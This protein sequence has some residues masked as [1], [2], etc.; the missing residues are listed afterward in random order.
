MTK[1]S[2][3]LPRGYAIKGYRVDK[4]IGGGGFSIVYLATTIDTG[5]Q[6]VIKE[7]MPSAQAQR[8][9]GGRVEPISETHNGLYRQGIKRFFDEGTVLAKVNHPNIV[10]VSNFFRA[11]NTVYMV[12]TYEQ[13]K[14]LRWYI[15]RHDGRLSEKFIR[16]VF[17]PLLGG[18][19][20]LHRNELLHLDIKPANIFL[21]PGGHPLLLDFGA[22]QGPALDNQS[23]P[24]TLT[25]GFAPIEQHNKNELGPYSDTYAIG[26]SIFACMSGRAPPPATER[27]V[28]DKHR[29]TVKTFARHYSPQLLEAV[30]WCLQMDPQDRPQSIDSLLEFLNAEREEEGESLASILNMPI[31]LPW[32]KS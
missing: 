22:A 3:A 24:N 12:M 23:G 30:D 28:K 9:G 5:E 17:P 20:E 21:R 29:P 19:R 8:V 6:V 13:G 32:Q 18:I 2:Q 15:K 7:C 27:L 10:H 4:V 1:D 11:N 26:A 31:R 25:P 16:A 14:D